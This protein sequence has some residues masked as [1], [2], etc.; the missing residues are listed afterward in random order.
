MFTSPVTVTIDAVDTDLNRINQDNYASE[1]LTERSTT[2]EMRM[3]IRNSSYVSSAGVKI[4]RHNIELVETVYAVAPETVDT[5]RKAYVVFE[6]ERSD[7]ATDPLNF[8]LGFAAF[9]TSA[10]IT[11]LLNMES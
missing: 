6:N 10:N 2:G 9:L 5:I 1:Y 3:R 11:K 7:G 8:N 4:D